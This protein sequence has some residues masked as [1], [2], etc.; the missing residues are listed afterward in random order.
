MKAK[1]MNKH[2]NCHCCLKRKVEVILTI[3]TNKLRGDDGDLDE[4]IRYFL[5]TE[6]TGLLFMGRQLPSE[7]I[8]P[9]QGSWKHYG[10][11]SRSPEKVGKVYLL[12]HALTMQQNQNVKW[13]NLVDTDKHFQGYEL[14]FAIPS[15]KNVRM[16]KQVTFF[17]T[18]LRMAKQVTFESFHHCN[19]L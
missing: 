15:D 13:I 1:K 9:L 16:A 7:G 5:I 10:S 19:N 2:C 6:W 18:S 14:C 11:Q 4:Y 8:L 12:R 17:I 3:V